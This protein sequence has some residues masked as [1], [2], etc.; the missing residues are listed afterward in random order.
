MRQSTTDAY[1][2]TGLVYRYLGVTNRRGGLRGVA[3]PELRRER[4]AAARAA[5]PPVPARRGPGTATACWL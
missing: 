3:P 1:E 2:V 5:A 4:R